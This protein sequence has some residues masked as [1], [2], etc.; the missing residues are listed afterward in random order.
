[1]NFPNF[2]VAASGHYL[3]TDQSAEV[4]QSAAEC[5]GAGSSAY[6]SKVKLGTALRA[7][8]AGAEE[9]RT[10]AQQSQLCSTG[11]T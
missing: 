2:L 6:G 5:R 9:S 11:A 1:M 8:S 4:Q 3:A 10:A 7:A